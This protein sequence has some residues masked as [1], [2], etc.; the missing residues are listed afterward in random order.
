[1]TRFSS[2]VPLFYISLILITACAREEQDIEAELPH[3]KIGMVGGLNSLDPS[4]DANEVTEVIKMALFEGLV[5]RNP[6][7]KGVVP[8]AAE[9]WDISDDG[10]TYTF[11]LRKDATWS[12]GTPIDAN[13]Y[14]D[15]WMYRLRN[16]EEKPVALFVIKGAE[17]YFEEGG[18][19]ESVA[20]RAIDDYT[21]RFELDRP[22]P[23]MLSNLVWAS[24][25]LLPLHAMEVHGDAW[26]D[27]GH[28]VCSG[29][30]VI[31]EW[32]EGD[33]LVVR[34][35]DTYW[36]RDNV[37]LGKVT[38]LFLDDPEAALEMFQAGEID[39]TTDPPDDRVTSLLGTSYARY[40]PAGASYYY[41]FN[42]QRSPLDDPRVRRALSMAVDRT[43][44]VSKVSGGLGYPAHRVTPPLPA[45]PNEQVI[46]FDAE[47]AARLLADAG[48]ANGDGFPELAITYND[49]PH[50]AAVAEFIAAEWEERLGITTEF[51]QVS[52]DEWREIGKTNDDFY[53]L[54]SGWI[55]G[56]DPYT[57]LSHHT[58]DDEMNRSGMSNREYD[59]LLDET[60]R[61]Q[62]GPP[63]YELFRK[64][65]KILIAEEAAVLPLYFYM[66]TNLIDT[67]KWGGWYENPTDD[68]HPLKFVYLK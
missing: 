13:G 67:E 25:S 52:V 43:E 68:A 11:A 3:F 38:Y 66:Y 28:I 60:N 36:D 49:R 55:G 29:A 8:G 65:E 2:I 62:D 39:W 15:T 16:T 33:R 61:M 26:A 35:S 64:A 21:F 10:L 63:R 59:S 22:V 51:R 19:P 6:E 27:P 20:I 32:V 23:W 9:S 40:N 50:H 30:F 46:P 53:M 24:F 57:Y 37:H 41:F 42:T 14:V 31:D 1:M 12:D 58:T 54:R 7:G 5:G 47:L 56:P 44:L 45:Y 18:S 4:K 17:S 34:R 48:F